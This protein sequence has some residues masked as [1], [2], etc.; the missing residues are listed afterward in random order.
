MLKA[1]IRRYASPRIAETLNRR[2]TGLTGNFFYV[3]TAQDNSRFLTSGE[4]YQK[5]QNLMRGTAGKKRRIPVH[6][7]FWKLY[8]K[9]KSLADREY[10]FLI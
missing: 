4:E 5:M 1:L 6:R 2:Y 7:W 8:E 9:Y 3:P 10:I